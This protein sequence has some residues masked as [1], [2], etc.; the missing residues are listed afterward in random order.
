MKFSFTEDQEALRESARVFL[1]DQSSSERVRAA[2]ESERG[3]DHDVWTRVAQEMGWTAITVPEDHGGLGLGYVELVALLEEMGAHVLCSPFFESICLGANAIMVGADD[4]QKSE[5]LPGIASGDTIATLAFTE[6]NGRWDASG[7]SATARRDGSDYVLEGV[8]DFVP[9]GNAAD[10]LVVAARRPGSSGT[11]GIGLFAVPSNSA[12]V[13]RTALPTMDQTRRQATVALNGVRVPASS[14]LGG[15]E[16]AWPA[17]E[18]TLQRAAVA[19]AAEQAGG[20]DRCLDMTV[21]YAKERVQ[22]GRQIGSFQAVKHKCADMLLR[23]ESARSAAYYAGWAASVDDAELPVLASLAKSYC[24]DAYFHC[25]A[26]SIQIH[27]GV[28]FTW[29]YDVHIHFKRAKST[30]TLLGSPAYHRELI[31]NGIGLGRGND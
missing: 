7:V 17:V 15:N 4:R 2:M 13:E 27:G 21:Q 20:A 28:G 6:K 11:D 23:V 31:A 1:A 29:E 3:Y 19:R 18:K 25:A 14:L 10:L 30:E 26:D 24:S 8:K 5:H 9:A 22:F 16:E 12:G